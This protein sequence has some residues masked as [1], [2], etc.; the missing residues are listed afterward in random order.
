MGVLGAK[1]A[2][3]R[4]VLAKSGQMWRRCILAFYSVD[5]HK[6]NTC[7]AP[8]CYRLI[9]N[10]LNNEQLLCYGRK[11]STSR[12]GKAVIPNIVGQGQSRLSCPAGSEARHGTI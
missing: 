10:E 2:I 6:T 5:D 9:V 7:C 8:S 1:V 4:G 12:T 11:R 3:F